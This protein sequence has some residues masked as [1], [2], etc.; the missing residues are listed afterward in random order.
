MT[1]SAT[2][3]CPSCGE[4][5]VLQMDPSSPPDAQ[6]SVLLADPP[7]RFVCAS[8]ACPTRSGLLL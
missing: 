7:F 6:A 3:R 4:E 1:G 5:L 8:S 2:S